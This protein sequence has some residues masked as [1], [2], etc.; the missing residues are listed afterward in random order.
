MILATGLSHYIFMKNTKKPVDIMTKEG[1]I[2]VV[3]FMAG[4]KRFYAFT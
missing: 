2:L 1:S 3:L 4:R